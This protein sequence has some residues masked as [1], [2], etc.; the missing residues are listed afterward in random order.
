MISTENHKVKAVQQIDTVSSTHPGLVP[1]KIDQLSISQDI[2]TRQ[3][4]HFLLLLSR[5]FSGLDYCLQK[6]Y[7]FSVF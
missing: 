2:L 4:I 5:S 7:L 6:I 3:S 1:D